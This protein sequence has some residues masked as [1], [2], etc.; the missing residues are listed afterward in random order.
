VDTS[1][2]VTATA[3]S[4]AIGLL[5]ALKAEYIIKLPDLDL[6]VQG[7][8]QLMPAKPP[9][10]ARKRREQTAPHG[11][12]TNYLREQG[13]DKMQ[14]GDVLSFKPEGFDAQRVRGVASSLG[15][16]CYGDGS[17]ITAVVNGVVEIMRVQ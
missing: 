15:G 16:K 8:M 1:K 3:L 14:V 6:I 5:T 13:V 4:R 7:D 11:A 12:Y 2:S 17:V 10:P 9:K